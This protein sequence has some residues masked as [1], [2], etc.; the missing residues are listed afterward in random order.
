MQGLRFRM[1]GSEF[2]RVSGFGVQGCMRVLG[3][4]FRVEFAV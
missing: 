3:S 2:G 1:Q 4:G